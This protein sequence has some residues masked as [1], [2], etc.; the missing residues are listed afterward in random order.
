MKLR[1]A[2]S[3]YFNE[4]INDSSSDTG[5]HDHRHDTQLD[6]KKSPHTLKMQNSKYLRIEDDF[7]SIAQQLN[8]MFEEH[9]LDP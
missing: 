8:Q 3:L 4:N 6:F 7:D 9:Y 5:H 1:N 2:I